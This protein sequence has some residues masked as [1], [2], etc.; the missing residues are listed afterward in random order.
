LSTELA[1]QTA[2]NARLTAELKQ[3]TA[4]VNDLSTR[5]D[6]LARNQNGKTDASTPSNMD[7]VARVNRLTTENQALREENSRL[8]RANQ[9]AGGG[10]RVR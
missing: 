3:K 2:D 4:T 6:A 10:E 5:I 1:Q 9:D 8:K 7:L